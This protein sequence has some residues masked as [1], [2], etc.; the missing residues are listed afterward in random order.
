MQV[1]EVVNI[2]GEKVEH[3]SEEDESEDV[4]S[5]EVEE[6][7]TAIEETTSEPISQVGLYT[8]FYYLL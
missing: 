8:F 3:A 6:P 4:D 1:K 7:V 5:E 2:N